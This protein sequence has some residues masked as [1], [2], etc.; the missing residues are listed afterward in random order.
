MKLKSYAPRNLLDFNKL[1]TVA[2]KTLPAGTP[3]RTA[4]T[5]A[6]KTAEEGGAEPEVKTKTKPTKPKKKKL[7]PPP[8]RVKAK[9]EKAKPEKTKPKAK[10][11][12]KKIRP[13]RAKAKAE[14]NETK[15]PDD[16][17]LARTEPDDI[18]LSTDDE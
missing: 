16:F 10:P 14:I 17:A 13:S 11:K 15:E 3:A 6:R 8:T 2:E 18:I 7:R 12:A 1:R 5:R 4:Q 9:P